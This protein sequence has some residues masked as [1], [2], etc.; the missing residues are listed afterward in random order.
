MKI[1]LDNINSIS[2]YVEIVQYVEIKHVFQNKII[3]KQV[4]H[5]WKARDIYRPDKN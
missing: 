5:E 2:K 3:Y 4:S 1:Q